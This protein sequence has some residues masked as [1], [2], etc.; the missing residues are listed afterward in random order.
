[1][2][3]GDDGTL[4][5]AGTGDVRLTGGYT[6][7][8]RGRALTREGA[9]VIA[10]PGHHACSSASTR[11]GDGVGRFVIQNDRGF[12]SSDLNAPAGLV[13]D[14]RIVKRFSDGNSADLGRLQRQR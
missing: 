8:V 11:Q 14:G 6:V 7:D 4:V 13:N 10:D 5:F 1:M 2:L 3:V 9:G 12:F